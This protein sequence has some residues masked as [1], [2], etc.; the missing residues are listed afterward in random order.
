MN[1]MLQHPDHHRVIVDRHQQEARAWA[2]AGL[3]GR[4]V[5]DSKKATS[6]PVGS[7]QRPADRHRLRRLVLLTNPTVVLAS[8]AG[9]L[10]GMLI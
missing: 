8:V 3:L 1:G 9:V 10:I 5:A 7:G 2:R 4:Q 6:N